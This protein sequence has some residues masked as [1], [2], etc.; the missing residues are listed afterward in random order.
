MYPRLVIRMDKLKENA[1]HILEMTAS[2]GISVSAVTKVFCA[3]FKVAEVLCQVG[4][5]SLAD[6][7]LEN[8]E[9]IQAIQS[10]KMLLRLP[11][12]SQAEKTVDLA[13]ISL[14]SELPVIR[15]LNRAAERAGK[16]HKILLMVDLGDL[17]E[18]VLPEQVPEFVEEILKMRHIELVGLGTNLTCYGGV[19]P[20]EENLGKLVALS[21]RIE[22][23]F[24]CHFTMLSGGNSSSLHL[25]QSGRLPREIT[26]LR[27]GESVV[28]G[29]E[30]A[31]G[32]LIEGMHPDVFTL[33]AEIVELKRKSSIPIGT[34]GRDA[35][36]KTPIFEDKGERLRA[37]LAVGRQ[38]VDPSGLTPESEGIEVIGASSDHLI[39]D[40]TE[41]DRGYAVGD[42]MSFRLNYSALLRLATSPY[43]TRVYIGK[44]GEE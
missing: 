22:R 44:S 37:I 24:G 18:G 4:F 30:T 40:V 32:T 5:T 23:D 1:T 38:D 31:Y 36:G 21:A 15:A 17:R 19:L 39:V 13:D 6:S 9:R 10:E 16:R 27:L 11:M 25:L 33:E 35:F 12:M 14:N 7:R 43:V 8:L 28:L 42:K 3:D 2:F 29:R 34:I 20:D 26:H 41:S